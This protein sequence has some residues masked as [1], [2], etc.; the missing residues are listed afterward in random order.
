MRFDLA[1]LAVEPCLDL[2]AIQTTIKHRQQASEASKEI[3]LGQFCA[4]AEDRAES[5]LYGMGRIDHEAS[6]A[7]DAACPSETKRGGPTLKAR[8][9][10][11]VLKGARLVAVLPELVAVLLEL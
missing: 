8:P 6:R 3:G 9:A 10:G 7:R 1:N 4:L 11:V 2:K 5:V